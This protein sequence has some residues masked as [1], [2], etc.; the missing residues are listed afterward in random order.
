[1]I[2]RP[3]TT[4]LPPRMTCTNNIIPTRFA[5]IRVRRVGCKTVQSLHSWDFR[6]S[7]LR[8]LDHPK[9]FYVLREITGLLTFRYGKGW[10]MLGVHFSPHLRY[11]D[12]ISPRSRPFSVRL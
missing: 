5:V 7:Y 1:M 3:R 6:F 9:I 8:R 12:K 4:A 10:T 2:G 11:A